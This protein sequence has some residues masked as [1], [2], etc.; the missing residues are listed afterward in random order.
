[1]LMCAASDLLPMLLSLCSL[2]TTKILTMC[3][4]N[5][6]GLYFQDTILS[7]TQKHRTELLPSGALLS[8]QYFRQPHFVA[9]LACWLTCFCAFASYL[10]YVQTLLLLYQ[11]KK[12]SQ[13]NCT[14]HLNPSVSAFILPVMKHQQISNSQQGHTS[15]FTHLCDHVS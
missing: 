13:R 3:L 11:Q 2:I 14:C 7:T 10:N 9:A 12:C 6:R 15:R 5:R 1:M 4:Q 8:C